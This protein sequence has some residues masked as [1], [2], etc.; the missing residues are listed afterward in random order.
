MSTDV[1]K[2]AP[3]PVV[4]ESIYE[5]AKDFHVRKY[6][7]YGHTDGKL[8]ATANHKTVVAKAEDVFNAALYGTLV[9]FDGTN[10]LTPVSFTASGF[11][12]VDGEATPAGKTWT[13]ATE[14]AADI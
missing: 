13:V 5:K 7:M 2:S 11:K 4:P 8:Y 9:I 1:I 6:I 12:T 10:Y 14:P 3:R